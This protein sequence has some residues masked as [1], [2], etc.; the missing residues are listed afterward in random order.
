MN[1]DFH[2][3]VIKVLA[4]AAGFKETE[5]QIIAYAS[6][7]TDDARIH[8][9]L[10]L[11]DQS[12]LKLEDEL[13]TWINLLG[14]GFKTDKKIV[15]Q[16]LD[17]IEFEP[18]CTAH[19][20]IDYANGVKT[21]A[22]RKVYVSFHFVPAQAYAKNKPFSFLTQPGLGAAKTLLGKIC[23][24]LT[25]DQ[26]QDRN[27]ALIALGLSLHSYADTWSHEGFSGLKSKVGNNLSQVL[28]NDK[29]TEKTS[30]MLLGEL[31]PCGHLQA[32]NWPDK[33]HAKINFIWPKRKND[34][35][36]DNT[37]HFADACKNIVDRISPVNK[38]DPDEIWNKIEKPLMEA[39]NLNINSDQRIGYMGDLFGK[40]AVTKGL[41]MSYDEMEWENRAIN[42]RF[43]LNEYYT[44]IYKRASK[45]ELWFK[46]HIAAAA[47]RAFVLSTLKP[48]LVGAGV[49]KKQGG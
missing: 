47:H 34:I 9:P 7:H 36:R 45:N 32:D 27:L 49:A 43:K 29:Q 25:N 13:K 6:Q 31:F 30:Q 16:H 11:K 40:L 19:K 10:V 28:V 46:F 2:Y 37:L 3:G 12:M 39:M 20:D 38:L 48:Y 17:G 44:P 18:V 24:I 14:G 41:K 33:P 23:D 26:S 35:K 5:A 15:D 42:P 4:R 1:K 8:N 22:Q 21:A